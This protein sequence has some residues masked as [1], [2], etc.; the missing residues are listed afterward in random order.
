MGSREDY[1][2]RSLMGGVASRGLAARKP[3]GPAVAAKKTLPRHGK[4]VVYVTPHKNAAVEEA[5]K[6]EKQGVKTEI[7]KEPDDT[8]TMV[9][10]VY[11]FE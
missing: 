3:V 6:Y 8:G 4:K 11:I 7:K 5:A 9:F 10:V 2:S 1:L